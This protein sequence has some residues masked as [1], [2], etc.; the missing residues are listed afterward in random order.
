MIAGAIIAPIFV[1]YET[2]SKNPMVDFS[3]FKD[4][5]LRY[6]ILASFFQSLGYLSVVFLI[7]MYLQG[8]RGLSPL[9]ASILL[10]PGY[11]VGSLLGPFM[12]KLSDKYGARAIASIGIAIIGVAILIYLILRQDS[13]LYLVLIASA[14]SGLGTSMFFPANNS[15]V[16]ASA[17]AGSYGSISGLL[18]TMAEHRHPRK[19]CYGHLCGLC[20]NPQIGGLRD[21]YRNDKPLRRRIK[22]VHR[23][24]GFGPFGLADIACNCRG[25]VD[26]QRR[27]EER[28]NK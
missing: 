20:I 3:A 1:I 12:G 11:V 23:W 16:M 14:I 26:N 9:D 15:A 7:I 19:L 6:S 13:S 10:I 8:V 25:D 28:L 4:K 17:H 22:G 21:I 18:R 5:V 24:N 27:R 2:R